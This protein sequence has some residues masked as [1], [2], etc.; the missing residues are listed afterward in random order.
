MTH[1]DIDF[2]ERHGFTRAELPY[3]RPIGVCLFCGN[4]IVRTREGHV[5]SFDGLFCNMECCHSYYEIDE[6]EY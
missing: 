6:E 4:D 1:P 5:K 2:V 3:T